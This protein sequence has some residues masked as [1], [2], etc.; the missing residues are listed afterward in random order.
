MVDV[1]AG[2]PPPDDDLDQDWVDPIQLLRDEQ[3]R[4]GLEPPAELEERDMPSVNFSVDMSQP[5]SPAMM[6]DQPFDMPSFDVQATEVATA[7]A[8]VAAAAA[9]TAAAMTNTTS[10]TAGDGIPDDALVTS[11]R[12]RYFI[13]VGEPLP[14]Y[15]SANAM[16]YQTMFRNDRNR[17]LMALV[18]EVEVQPRYDVLEGLRGSGVAGMLKI[19]EWGV[20]DW[21]AGGSRFAVVLDRPGGFRVVDDFNVPQPGL[22]DTEIIEGLLRPMLGAMKD[23]QARGITHRGIRPTNLFYTDMGRRTMAL[24]DCVTTP[25]G[26]DQPSL[27]ETIEAAQAHPAGRGPGTLAN[28]LYAL[29]ATIVYLLLGRNPV[30]DKSDEALIREK[31]EVGSYMALAGQ[32]RIP[33]SLAEPVRGLL[34]DD[35]RDR[36]TVNDFDLWLSG[37]RQSP[38]Q[39]KLPSRASRPFIVGDLECFNVRTLA[40]ALSAN[41]QDA[42]TLVRSK[43]MD[44]WLRRSMMEEPKAEALMSAVYSTASHVTGRG[45]EERLVSRASI[46]LDPRAPI[47]YRNIGITVDGVGYAMTAAIHDSDLRAAVTEI[48]SARLP[49][50][51]VAAQGKPNSEDVRIAQSME[52]LPG[53]IEQGA[54]GLGFERCLYELNPAMRC[55]SPMFEREFVVDISEVMPALDRLG[56]TPDRPDMPF[57]RHLI[58]FIAARSKRWS[59]ELLRPLASPDTIIRAIGLLRLFSYVQENNEVGPVPGFAGWM[60]VMLSPVLDNYHHRTRRQRVQS[61]VQAAAESGILSE[62]LAVVDDLAERQADNYGFHQASEEYRQIEAE[63]TDMETNVDQREDDARMMGEQIAAVIGSVLVCIVTAITFL[64]F[65]A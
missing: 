46:T 13:N 52:R 17:P 40:H 51:W 56:Q 47:L 23:L 48:I 29:G 63:L 4:L 33:S 62:L 58:G 28:D 2:G 53:V 3:A 25:P 36:W 12:G 55:L 22:S 57:D 19:L 54:V 16:A 15:A 26:F 18:C 8:G 21:P 6:V 60:A 43:Q 35:E 50:H 61:K 64:V 27:F 38:R 20:V 34:V 11:L 37:R 49:M 65:Y 7:A 30:A 5:D 41:W 42:V 24:G 10:A 45:A 39:G 32:V 59:E 44:S 31:I 9:A 14:E 1:T